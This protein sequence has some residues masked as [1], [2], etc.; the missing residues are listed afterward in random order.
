MRHSDFIW[1][2]IGKKREIFCNL[3]YA[4]GAESCISFFA[5]TETDYL[6]WQVRKWNWSMILPKFPNRNKF[7]SVIFTRKKNVL[8]LFDQ[9]LTEMILIPVINK[10]ILLQN[11][12]HWMLEACAK[13][14]NGYL[15]IAIDSN[16]RNFSDKIFL[17]YKKYLI[18]FLSFKLQSYSAHLYHRQNAQ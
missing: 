14:N 12:T 17:S 8:Y 9:F 16:F 10:D 1:E 2:K 6:H 13:M 11:M 18:E 3:K 7:W 5:L 4:L 15:T